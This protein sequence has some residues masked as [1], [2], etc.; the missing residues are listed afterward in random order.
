M[1][2]MQAY[3]QSRTDAWNQQV[4]GDQVRQNAQRA[5]SSSWRKTLTRL[6]DAVDP[7]T[8]NHFQVWTGPNA[9]DYRNG[10]GQTGAGY[11]QVETP[12]Q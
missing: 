1:G 7:P 5:Q 2:Q 12:P 3:H 10:L 8:G 4:A 6:T 11:Q 9:N